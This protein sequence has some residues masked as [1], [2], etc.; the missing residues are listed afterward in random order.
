LE[1]AFEAQMAG[2]AIVLVTH[3]ER[4]E[5]YQDQFLARGVRVM[6]EPA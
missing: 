4:A 3:R 5:L 6:I 2:I 1:A